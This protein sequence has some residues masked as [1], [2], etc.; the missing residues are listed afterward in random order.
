MPEAPFDALVGI[1]ILAVL[2]VQNG[3]CR[4]RQIQ[5]GEIKMTEK[6]AERLIALV[7]AL[8]EHLLLVFFAVVFVAIMVMTK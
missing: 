7:E 4:E 2:I 8:D 5:A 3:I 1:D 6:Q